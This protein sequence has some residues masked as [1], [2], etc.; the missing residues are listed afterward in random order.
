MVKWLLC[1]LG[2]AVAW[3]QP[4]AAVYGP[5]V[6]LHA[7]GQP[8]AEVF[9]AVGRQLNRVFTGPALQGARRREPLDLDLDEATVAETLA[10]LSEAAGA[11]IV[12]Q[13]PHVYRVGETRQPGGEIGQPLG[14]FRCWLR[15]MRYLFYS[16]YFPAGPGRVARSAYLSPSLA[17]E[18]PSDPE[19]LRI[20]SVSPPTALTDGGDELASV[21]NRTRPTG[22]SGGDPRSWLF[23]DLL[24][25]RGLPVPSLAR[26]W[27]DVTFVE[28][29]VARRYLFRLADGPGQ[30]QSDGEFDALLEPAEE[31]AG[32]SA[33]ALVTL[34]CPV[35]LDPEAPA[36]PD[37]IG[38]EGQFFD[39]TDRPLYTIGTGN[40]AAV[41]EGLWQNQWRFRLY[42]TDRKVEPVRLDVR[43]YVPEGLGVTERVTFEHLAVPPRSDDPEA[44]PEGE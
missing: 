35:G 13:A 11:P 26:L 39:A 19:A 2:A 15:S 24:N 5:R 42:A 16:T 14:D 44:Q 38:V 29:L 25:T 22:P 17:I 1:L 12:R 7:T 3:G 33:G 23:A 18:A 27:F 30:L 28:E 32:W 37:R 9:D 20:A 8:A 31:E 40:A 4:P 34:R 21:P 6:T 41:D 36:G 43:L 10:A